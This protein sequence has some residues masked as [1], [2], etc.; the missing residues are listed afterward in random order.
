MR[1]FLLAMSLLTFLGLKSAQA[2]PVGAAAPVLEAINQD[3]QK[4]NFGDH[5]R[6]G[7]VLV[8]F[9][10]KADTPGCTAQACSLRDAYTDLLQEGVTVIGVSHDSP[11][12]QKKFQTKYHLPFVLIADQ[13]GAVARAFQVPTVIGFTKR[14]AFLIRDGK[15]V[16][17]DFSA[18]T[19][20]QA[21]DVKK[22]IRGMGA[23]N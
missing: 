22:A 14:Q 3:G 10:P 6:K 9:Y 23:K 13:D 17:A 11:D 12:A 20:K 4:V 15:V 19:D 21:D 5:Y 16:W 18:S 7:L 2:L 8:Y 1:K